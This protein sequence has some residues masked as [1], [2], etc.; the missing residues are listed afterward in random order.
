MKLRR[1]AVLP[2]AVILHKRTA[3]RIGRF[4][5]GK[6]AGILFDHLFGLRS[7]RTTHL[8]KRMDINGLGPPKN[9]VA[10]QSIQTQGHVRSLKQP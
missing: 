6:E 10:D 2:I 4:R 5:V 3:A 9:C 7:I 1:K 8:R